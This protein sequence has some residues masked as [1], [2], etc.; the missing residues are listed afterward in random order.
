MQSA[1]AFESRSLGDLQMQ[2]RSRTPSDMNE[3]LLKIMSVTVTFLNK[4]FQQQFTDVKAGEKFDKISLSVTTYGME[5][6]EDGGYVARASFDARAYFQEGTAPTEQDAIAFATEA[7]QQGNQEFL[8]ALIDTQDPF[9]SDISYAVVKVNGKRLDGAEDNDG[10][11]SSG[12]QWTGWTDHNWALGLVAG[13]VSFFLVLCLCL[14]CIWC[15]PV[16]D[17]D[18]AE[19]VRKTISKAST[20]QT[21][22]R[23]DASNRSPSPVQSIGSQDSSVF[24]Y[25]PKSNVS[26]TS[27]IFTYGHPASTLSQGTTST[28]AFGG[29]SVFTSNSGLELDAEAWRKGS[30]VSKGDSSIFGGQNISAIETKKDLSLIEEGSE[31]GD[32]VEEIPSI[33]HLKKMHTTT[34]IKPVSLSEYALADLESGE[35]E[36]TRTSSASHSTSSSSR[37][38]RESSQ[39]SH[40]SRRTTASALTTPVSN[41]Q[42]N[43]IEDLD[44]LGSQFD[45]HRKPR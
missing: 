40:K 29:A 11:R 5:L 39:H 10:K 32:D 2:I 31:G 25:N 1:L 19:P 15:T 23:S 12:I 8:Q 18:L 4:T 42:A 30:T 20:G 7:L 36:I 21:S 9:L 35:R 37:G 16:D 44:S 27:S 26:T 45:R 34:S 43:V 38:S 14:I 6:A 33:L 28:P 41:V 22:K 17:E 13:A 3:V 24:T